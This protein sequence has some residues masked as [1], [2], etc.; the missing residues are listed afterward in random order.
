MGRG[1]R[2]WAAVAAIVVAAALAAALVAGRAGWNFGTAPRFAYTDVPLLEREFQPTEEG[3]TRQPVGLQTV[4]DSLF[5]SYNGSNVLDCFNGDLVRVAEI[6]LRAPELILPTDFRVVGSRIL[7]AD[8]A[9]GVVAIFD[10][11][12][13]YL[14]S[15]DRLPD[16]A[17]RLMPFALTHHGSVLYVSDTGIGRVLAISLGTEAGGTESGEIILGFPAGTEEAFEYPTAVHVTDDGRLL[18]GDSGRSTIDV[19]TCSG[20]PVYRF[21]AVPGRERISPHGF[22]QDD[23]VDPEA[24]KEDSM[25]PS[26]LRRQGRVHAVDRLGGQVHLY[27]PLGRYL[28]S[29]P[30]AGN[31]ARPSAV[32]V[33]AGR[34]RVFVA[35]PAQGLILVYRYKGR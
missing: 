32:A 2:I 27:S 7:V 18:V 1:A 24:S 4:G 22:A 31:L 12:G 19:F 17:T 15:Y 6:E 3:P 20:R 5:V 13:H 10:R 9:R 28:A 8:H 30:A 34:G 14:D 35:D 29:Y 21:D 33:N 16:G 23:V 26:G 25:D 11:G